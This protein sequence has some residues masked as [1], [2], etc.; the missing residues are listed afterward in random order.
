M[1]THSVADFQRIADFKKDT[2]GMENYP[3]DANVRIKMHRD[4]LLVR[5]CEETIAEIYH[6]QEIRT[7][8]H[9]GSGQEAVAV[10]VCSAL[11]EG[12]TA[13]SHHRCHNHY[14]AKGGDVYRL[15]AELY[16]RAD[17]CSGGR[18]GSVHL[19]D[20][21]VGFLATSAIVGQMVAV[22]VGN[23]LSMKMDKKDNVA[24]TFFG[25]AT[26]EEGVFYESLNFAAIQN[27]PV[28]FVCEN[29]LYSTESPLS[30]R[31]A[32]G[33]S[34]TDRAKSM[35][36]DATCIDGNDVMATHQIT[37]EVVE[38]MRAG[39]GPFFLECETYRHREHVGPE[40]DHEVGRAYR[41]ADEFNYWLEKC[42]I[43]I[44]AAKLLDGGLATEDDLASWETEM[45]GVVD[46]CIV[47]AKAADWPKQS[48]LFS[49]TVA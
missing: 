44:S 38:K 13:V 21:S 37:S 35:G 4:M 9:L 11:R 45:Q 34:F 42:P 8:T 41:S 6:E 22:A 25:D 17:G 12:D 15:F 2:V 36:V 7:P 39:G 46:D 18:G 20:Q 5:R 19:T 3:L 16:G 32:E 23:A 14:L 1:A 48:T 24:V 47:R 10:G 27:L 43:K 33:T 28:L 26:C 30:T 40:F 31:R 49:H 29:N